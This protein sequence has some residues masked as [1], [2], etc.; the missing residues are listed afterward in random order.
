MGHLTRAM[1]VAGALQQQLPAEVSLLIQG[2]QVQR[3]DL[4]RLRHRFIP[5]NTELGR[6]VLDET[7][8]F[9]PKLV[10][11][12][13]HPRLLPDDLSQLLSGLRESGARLIGID[14]LLDYCNGLDLTWI[15]A[16][17]IDP[18][19]MAHCRAPVHFGWDSF[20]L[21]RTR[22]PGVWSPGNRVLVLT[23][24]SDA[25]G[26]GC[27]LPA[28]MDAVLPLGIEVHWVRGPYAPA[29]VLPPAPRLRWL[30][31][32]SPEGLDDLMVGVNYALTVFGVSCFELLQYGVPTVVFSPYGGKDEAE[33]AGLA[34]AGVAWVAA[35]EEVA[36]QRL[37]RLMEDDSAAARLAQVSAARM[38]ARGVDRL[39]E[40]IR[41]ILG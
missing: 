30:I 3:C 19:R 41:E 18:A 34:E 15:P 24:G 32:N 7:A 36:V 25:A 23:G 40:R 4:E 6:A 28:R 13:L 10:I 5:L 22:T 35:D 14:S 26:S 16:F 12:D 2:E 21:R 20:L 9:D 1:V 37:R 31:E 39:V 38:S 8:A 33:L 27:E 29:P 17:R 11:F